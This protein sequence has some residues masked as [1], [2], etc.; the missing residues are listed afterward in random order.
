M[1]GCV[2]RGQDLGATLRLR[3]S[4]EVVLGICNCIMVEF[5]FAAKT[6]HWPIPSSFSPNVHMLYRLDIFIHIRKYPNSIH[7]YLSHNLPHWPKK[8]R[9]SQPRRFIFLAARL[10]DFRRQQKSFRKC[11]GFLK[12]G[13]PRSLFF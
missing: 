9:L 10:L 12:W 5:I 11:E 2:A 7:Q 1:L 6:F 4:S 8:S 13:I 3:K